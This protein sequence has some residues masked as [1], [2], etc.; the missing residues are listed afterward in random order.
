LAGTELRRATPDAGQRRPAS[1]TILA[2]DAA[3]PRHSEASAAALGGGGVLLLWSEFS[4]A[5]DNH[6]SRIAAMESHDG[7]ETW[8]VR[9]VVVE[10][11]AG[12]NVMSPAVRR[13]TDG[14]LGLLYSHRDSATEASRLFSRSDDEGRTWSA[15]VRLPQAEPYQTGCH[16]RLTVLDNGRLVAPLHCTADWRAHHLHVRCAWSDDGGATWRLSGPIALPRVSDSGESGC[17]EPDVAQRADGSLL[18][19]IRTAMGTIFRAESHDGGETWAG[20]RSMEVVAPVAPSLLRRI[21][22]TADLLLIWNWHY[23][24]REPLAGVRRPLACAISADGGDSWPL[25]RRKILEVDPAH[26]YAYPSC[27]FLDGE[28]LVTYH[29]TP[30]GEEGTPFAHQRSLRLVRVPLEWLYA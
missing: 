12:I 24:W 6:G 7:G 26:T 19:A 30:A 8:G 13:L 14:G 17:I 18:M 23:D 28:A 11:T 22:G 5:H 3:H 20:L 9:R 10:N 1:R 2:A 15:P 29:V 27:L 16:D 4:G 21:P 25:E